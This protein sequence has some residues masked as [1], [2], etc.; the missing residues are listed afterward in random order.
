MNMLEITG[1]AQP[2]APDDIVAVIGCGTMGVGIAQVAALGG[3]PVRLFDVRSGA[4]QSATTEIGSQLKKLV[5]KGSM[6]ATRSEAAIARL[7]PVPSL[8]DVAP[9]GLVIEAVQ[10]DLTVKQ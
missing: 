3:H 4:A 5:G 1:D 10:E 9:A 7:Q 6:D 8:S 2:L